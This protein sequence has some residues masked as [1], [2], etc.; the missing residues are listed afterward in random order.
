M[1]QPLCSPGKYSS[2]LPSSCDLT[3]GILSKGPSSIQTEAKIHL[4]TTTS[5]S[6]PIVSSCFPHAVCCPVVP[7]LG[8][9]LFSSR[10]WVSVSCQPLG[11]SDVL[12][13]SLS[14]C[15]APC[16]LRPCHFKHHR[17]WSCL[18]SFL[19]LLS[20]GGWGLILESWDLSH[21]T[22]GCIFQITHILSWSG[23]KRTLDFW[24]CFTINSL[25]TD[26]PAKPG[27][28][29]ASSGVLMFVNKKGFALGSWWQPELFCRHKL[30]LLG[31]VHLQKPV[32]TWGREGLAHELRQKCP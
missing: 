1:K 12:A 32:L 16:W 29:G 14:L 4:L 20:P 31:A 23:S 27:E 17:W 2:L 30:Q 6:L 28:H 11:D 15:A 18:F 24:T 9:S 13:L 7:S 25:M 5:C 21:W 19:Q 10:S 26:S 8:M 22:Q 3:G